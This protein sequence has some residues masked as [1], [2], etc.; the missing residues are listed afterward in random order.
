MQIYLIQGRL[1]LL[2]TD[3]GFLNELDHVWE[4]L[5]DVDG[6]GDFLDGTFRWTSPSESQ[7]RREKASKDSQDIVAGH[8]IDVL[9]VEDNL[10]RIDMGYVCLGWTP[11]GGMCTLELFLQ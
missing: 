4:T 7:Q 1:L 11:V 2:V 3:Y 8:N 9:K 10:D 5:E 6:G